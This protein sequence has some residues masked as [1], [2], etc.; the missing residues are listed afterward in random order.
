MNISNR[1]SCVWVFFVTGSKAVTEELAMET[2][3][4]DPPSGPPF[5]DMLS[6]QGVLLGQH[7]Q[8]LS[9]LQAENQHLHQALKDLCTYNANLSPRS[10]PTA[11]TREP[12]APDPELYDGTLGK[13]HGFLFQCSHVFALCHQT[14]LSDKPRFPL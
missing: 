9:A 6:R 4:A 11:A 14:F 13:C 3:P 12:R 2:D 5:C 8:A 10:L 7:D 1:E